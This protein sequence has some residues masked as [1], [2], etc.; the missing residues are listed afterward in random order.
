M[1]TVTFGR[2]Q[3]EDQR[4]TAKL[5]FSWSHVT[6]AQSGKVILHIMTLFSHYHY[7]PTGTMLSVSAKQGDECCWL[8]FS[9]IIPL[10]YF[11]VWKVLIYLDRTTIGI[12]CLAHL[13]SILLSVVSSSVSIH[14]LYLL[15]FHS[16]PIFSD[17]PSDFSTTE[18]F[19]IKTGKNWWR[20]Q[21]YCI[22]CFPTCG[23]QCPVFFL[24]AHLPGT[25]WIL[26][27][28]N[29]VQSNH[30]SF[31]LWHISSP[32]SQQKNERKYRS[33]AL[34]SWNK[35]TLT[36]D[37]RKQNAL[38]DVAVDTRRRVKE[39]KNRGRG[40]KLVSRCGGCGMCRSS[41]DK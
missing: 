41:L 24:L 14:S 5:H 4:V 28:F 20:Y 30:H 7:S 8:I 35:S 3:K 18:V 22:H 12:T 15:H 36:I 34:Q 32:C 19:Q 37:G 9:C 17:H 6:P 25:I 39:I 38:L 21:A 31:P 33:S 27:A 29:T 16:S 11:I 2:S 40:G 23:G 10:C 26:S 1:E 13:P